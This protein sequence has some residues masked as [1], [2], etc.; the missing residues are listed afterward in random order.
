MAYSRFSDSDIYI[1]PSID[2]VIV[3][4]GCLMSDGSFSI[5]NDTDLINHIKSHRHAGHYIP[6]GLEEDILNDHDRYGV[7]A[8]REQRALSYA[9]EQ[10]ERCNDLVNQFNITKE[11]A[12]EIMSMHPIMADQDKAA[13]TL[14]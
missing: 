8:P 3:C 7:Y 9:L 14:S 11:Q 4:A 12:L 6:K 2:G 1:Y 13:Q 10:E 5:D